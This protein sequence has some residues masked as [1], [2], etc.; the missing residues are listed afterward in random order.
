M[1]TYKRIDKQS[2]RKEMSMSI[3]DFPESEYSSLVL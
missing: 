3:T 2:N 1:K